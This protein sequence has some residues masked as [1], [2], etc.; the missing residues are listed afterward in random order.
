MAL[1]FPVLL[2]V[3]VGLALGGRLGGLA[4]LPLRAPWLFLVAFGLQVIAFPFAV[5]PWSTDL[6][7]AKA[8]WLVSYATLFVAMALNIRIRGVAIVGAGMCAN[9]V[10]IIANGGTMP[11]LPEAM[12][13]AGRSEAVVH[14]STSSERP[15]LSWI[16]DRWAAP[17]WIPLANVF[18]IGDVLI[19]IGAFVVVLSA[20]DVRLPRI[21]L[22]RTELPD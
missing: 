1:A 4:E 8:L 5:L 18:S 13:D 12:R 7:L 10:A 3:V 15:A 9:A 16:V 21:G 17:D 11:V 20:M 6:T 14:N 2:A 19:A 22:S